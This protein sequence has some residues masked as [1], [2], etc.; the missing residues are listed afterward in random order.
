MRETIK[1][2][3]KKLVLLKIFPPHFEISAKKLIFFLHVTKTLYLGTVKSWS[4]L[5]IR[6][7]VISN[8]NTRTNLHPNLTNR[9][10]GHQK[11]FFFIFVTYHPKLTILTGKTLNLFFLHQAPYSFSY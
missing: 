9:K 6:V 4:H 5:L 10:V 3:A 8:L 2:F 7:N 11:M 1:T